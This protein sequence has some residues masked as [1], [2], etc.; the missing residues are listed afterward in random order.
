ML[1]LRVSGFSR[2]TG[3]QIL[4]LLFGLAQQHQHALVVVTHAPEVAARCDRV[5]RLENGL[6]LP[7]Q[8]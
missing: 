2:D 4:E 3:A 1:V 5:L 8:A 7:G 6:L